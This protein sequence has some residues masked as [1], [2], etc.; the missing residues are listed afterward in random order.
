MR[1]AIIVL[2]ILITINTLY[3]PSSEKFTVWDIMDTYTLQEITVMPVDKKKLNLLAR[4]I[5]AEDGNQPFESN[6]WNGQTVLNYAE[7]R[8]LTFYESYYKPNRYYGRFNSVYK[9]GRIK[10][11]ALLAA[12]MLLKGYR[13]AP[14]EVEYFIGKYDTDTKFLAWVIPVKK[15]GYHTYCKRPDT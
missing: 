6:L 7:N 12:K 8:G 14:K 1:N 9:S 10:P 5:T 2:L 4:L 13:P 11:N 3:A 15:I